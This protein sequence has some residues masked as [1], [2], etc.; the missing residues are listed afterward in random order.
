VDTADTGLTGCG[1]WDGVRLLLT[2]Q[3]AERLEGCY[4]PVGTTFYFTYEEDSGMDPTVAPTPEPA[5]TGAPAALPAEPVAPQSAAAP[6]PSDNTVVAET[7]APTADNLGDLA[8]KVDDPVLVVTLAIIALL[9]VGLWKHLGKV[10]DQKAAIDMKRLEIEA[11]SVK[12]SPKAQPPPCQAANAALE[13]KLSALE[14][15]LGKVESSSLALPAGFDAE[16]LDERVRKLELEKLK[17]G[18]A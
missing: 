12:R 6:Q 11:D 10:A 14:A 13:A 4:I 3:T 17:K 5:F 7:P 16:E 1:L 18:D 9:G 15:R 2:G 8:Q